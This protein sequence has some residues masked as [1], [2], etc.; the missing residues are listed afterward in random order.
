MTA[1]KAS[2]RKILEKA[3]S[4][5]E[6]AHSGQKRQSGEP[7]IT[8][9]IAVRDMLEEVNADP[10]TLTAALLHDTIEDTGTSYEEIRKQFGPTVAKLVE[11]VTKVQQLE[12][13]M[14]KRERNMQSIRK[15][16][17]TM[18]KDIRVMF[19]KLA[20]RLHNMRTLG[21]TE[22]EKQQRIARETQD[23]YCPVADLLGI[24]VWFR[25]LSDICFRTLD[26]TGYELVR[27]KADVAWES[28]HVSLEKWA[29]AL[30]ATLHADGWRKA[31]VR[32]FR[33]NYEE[34]Y[35]KTHGRESDLQHIETFCAVHIIIPDDQDCYACMGATHRHVTPIPSELHDF[36]AAPKLNGYSAL[37]SS[38]MTPSGNAID[39]VFQTQTMLDRSHLGSL[40]MYR[41][42]PTKKSQKTVPDW[43][44]AIIWLEQDEQDTGAFFDILHSEIFG[45]RV[46]V[47]IG[48]SRRKHLE[49]P[50]GSTLL[51]VAFYVDEETGLR[52]ESATVNHQEVNLKSI[53]SDG[54]MIQFKKDGKRSQRDVADLRYLRTSLA[55]KVFMSHLCVLPLRERIRH[56]ASQL[57]HAI[58][59]SMD[60]FFGIE[61]Q[62]QI[63]ANI[64]QDSNDLSNIGTGSLNPFVYMQE[65]AA[66][67]DFFLLDPKCFVM[68]SRL[69]PSAGMHY[70]LR[71]TLSE[72]RAGNIIGLQVGPDVIDI[73]SADVLVNERRF[74]KEYVPIRARPASLEYPFLFALRFRYEQ[75]ANPLAGI[76]TLQYMLDTPVNLLQFESGS[77]TLGFHTDNLRTVQVAYEY[78]SALPYVHDI[79]RITPP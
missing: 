6:K 52:A 49:V 27:R 4:F 67:E 24:D 7:Y 22:P 72:L 51:D 1:M 29:N 30:Q 18:G 20:D 60:P 31:K 77:V 43:V 74:S 11:G 12:G 76:S 41:E 47:Y 8:H 63:R 38:V 55:R 70:V 35:T 62:K 19:I 71:T 53:V 73:I 23:I 64:M 39:L 26:P 65:H 58:D 28:Q 17:R 10:E 34:I 78:L 3:L 48:N 25:E 45:E 13:Q 14:D 44:S 66:P 2:E 68:L 9:L 15:I 54:D 46:R 32:I 37:H 79:F 56:G 33:R 40:M 75:H 57:Q 50:V 5:A 42:Q 21:Y 69:S 36:I 59:I 16:F 61:W